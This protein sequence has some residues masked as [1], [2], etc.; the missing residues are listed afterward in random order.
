MLN[1][2]LIQAK[3]AV[4]HILKAGRVPMCYSSPGMGKTSMAYEI[5]KEWQLFPIDVRLGQRDPTDLLG[6][7]SVDKTKEKASHVPFDTFPLEGDEPPEGYRGWLIIWDEFNAVQSLVLQAAAY[8][9]LLEKRIGNRKL[10]PHV[11]Q[12]CL[13]NKLTDKAIVTKF[14]S[15]MQSRLVHLE[16]CSDANVW[17]KY[18]N[19]KDFDYRV[20]SYIEFQPHHLNTFDPNHND[21]TYRCERTWEFT[22]D[23]ISG[24]EELGPELLPILAG[25]IGEGGGREFFAYCQQA[26]KLPRLEEIVKSPEEVKLHS[27]PAVQ[28]ALSGLVAYYMSPENAEPLM[29]FINR[30]NVDF[31]VITLRN[32]LQRNPKMLD[33]SHIQSWIKLH[34]RELANL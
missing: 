12:L 8:Q 28:Y 18:A 3:K 13:G 5:A 20:T 7:I 10:H 16:L 2:N 26:E 11:L 4:K 29:R 33:N 1:I 27:E 34:S 6:A 22:S 9:V 21:C 23:L 24:H 25:T 14:R 32:M 30:L 19:S 17:L 31:Q 15:A